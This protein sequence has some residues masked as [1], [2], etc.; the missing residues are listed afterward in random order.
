MDELLKIPTCSGDRSSLREVYDKITVNVKDLLA[1]GVGA[2]QYR[3]L[4]IPL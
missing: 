2:K 1:L 4:L 3:S